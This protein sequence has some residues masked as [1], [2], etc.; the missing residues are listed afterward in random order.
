MRLLILARQQAQSLGGFACTNPR[1]GG[2]TSNPDGC[3]RCNSPVR[4]R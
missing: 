3:G 1:C 2:I 4:P